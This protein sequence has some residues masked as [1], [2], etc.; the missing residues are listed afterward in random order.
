MSAMRNTLFRRLAVTFVCILSMIAQADDE[1]L[2]LLF[3][4]NSYTFFYDLPGFVAEL[5]VADGYEAPRLIVDL[6]G[7]EYVGYHW[8]QLQFAP[9]NNLAHPDILGLTFDYT[10]IQGHAEGATT[11][12]DPSNEFVPD[13]I[14][15]SQTVRDAPSGNNAGIV[16][17]QPWG[18]ALSH[19]VYAHAFDSPQTMQRQI[20]SNY[21]LARAQI[22]QL[23][24]PAA[25]QIAPVGDAFEA[26]SFSGSLYEFDHFHPSA[27]GS[28]LAAMILYRT[29]YKEQVSDIQF[30]M[31]ETPFLTEANWTFV[32]ALADATNISAANSLSDDDGDGAYD[33]FDNC[34]A[35]ANA[36]QY[37]SDQ[38][39]FGN[40]CDADFNNDCVINFVDIN[41]FSTAFASSSEDFDLN[42]DGVVNFL[43]FSV[44]AGLFLNPPG[45]SARAQC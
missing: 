12:N 15:W 16:L 24:A 21:A 38:D 42:N 41:M 27:M 40:V 17:F 13:L 10:V 25:A 22:N 26:A 11:L 36:D 8:S 14:G 43:D 35:T 28:R 30:S 19:P 31:I 6:Q 4:G 29:L 33:L 18:H 44:L 37:D 1:R 7:G 20:R 39:G 2:N 34:L 45:P 3:M 32:T 5:A 9:Q 23:V